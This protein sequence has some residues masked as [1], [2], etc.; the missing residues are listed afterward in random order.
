MRWIRL[1]VILALLT[2]AVSC[3]RVS[4]PPPEGFAELKGGR[5]YRA[6]SPEGMLY[7][8]RSIKNDP[9]KDLEFWGRALEN[10]LL[11]EGYRLNGEARPFD[12]GERRGLSYEWV[13]PYGNE[14]HLYLTALVVTDRTITLAEAAAAYPVFIRYRQAI[15]DSLSGIEPRR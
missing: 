12:S 9:G 3:S 14:S 11:K 4:V 10:H 7:R 5:S 2:L 13:L 8:V 15:L 1:A 6:I